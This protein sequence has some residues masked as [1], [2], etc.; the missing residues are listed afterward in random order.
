[1][2]P[3]LFHVDGERLY[4]ALLA[5][6]VLSFFVERAL[7]LVFEHRFFVDRLSGKGVK[8]FIAFGAALATCINWDFDAV[9]VILVSEKTSRLGH[10]ITAAVIAGGSKASVKFFQDVLGASSSAEKE[11]K[12]A[13]LKRRRDPEGAV[14]AT[15]EP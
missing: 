10:V 13:D 15:V 5:I 9:S 2:D 3:N 8:E 4:E 6:V 7:A 1:V 11:R 12:A 14:P